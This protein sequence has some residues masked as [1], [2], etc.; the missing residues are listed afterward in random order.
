MDR[1]NVYT[2]GPDG[3]RTF[4][5]WFD[6]DAATVF[7]EAP[8]Q[9]RHRPTEREHRRREELWLT[10]GGAWVI[11]RWGQL[12]GDAGRWAF[13]P[14]QDARV[15]LDENGHPGV[16]TGS[17]G[18]SR[19]VPP[20]MGRPRVGQRVAIAV[21]DDLIARV[22]AAADEA[23]VTRAEWLRRVIACAHPPC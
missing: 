16:P 14:A 22:N 23:G 8:G 1:V 3:T 7:H 21:P 9:V 20:V 12:R 11:H 5:G 17:G 15:W 18:E 6:R 10:T 13:L 19:G 2:V 4:A